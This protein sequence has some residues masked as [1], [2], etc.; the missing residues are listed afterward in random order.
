MIPMPRLLNA[1]LGEERRI[2]P[3]QVSIS[4]SITPL[5]TAQAL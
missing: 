3:I 2:R 4:E 1:S 5:T